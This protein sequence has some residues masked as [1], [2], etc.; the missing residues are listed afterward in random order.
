MNL[1]RI[2]VLLVEDNPVDVCFI[3]ANLGGSPGFPPIELEYAADLAESLRMLAAAEFDA[4]LLDLTLPDSSG[5]ETLFSVMAGSPHLAIVVLTGMDDERLA[6]EAVQRG[7]QDY[8]VKGK[9]DGELLDRALRYAIER[10]RAEQ[11][12]A[13]R[14]AEMARINELLRREVEGLARAEKA[15]D[16]ERRRLLHSLEMQE[17]DRQLIAYDIHDGLVQLI[18]AAHMNL[19]SCLADREKHPER[20]WDR[21]ADGLQLVGRGIAE[22]RRLIEGLRPTGLEHSGVK[23]AIEYLVRQ[24]QHSGGPAVEFR[25]DVRFSRLSAA[26]ETTIFR[27]VQEALNNA[28]RHSKSDRVRVE[29]VQQGNTLHLEVEDWGVGFCPDEI[30]AGHFGIRGMR[31]RARLFGGSLEVRVTP[32]DGSRIVVDLPIQEAAFSQS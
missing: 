28:M 13:E 25:S 6:L 30:E 10:K 3:K 27:I 24:A 18:T 32:G 17:R 12:L 31:D 1:D 26:L 9:V 21:M 14:A 11:T 15:L 16:Q 19:E 22:A 4:V 2:R 23:A 7:A 5:P 29:M 20:A 8:L